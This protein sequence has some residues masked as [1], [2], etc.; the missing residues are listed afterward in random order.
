MTMHPLS[1]I[2]VLFSL[3]PM[4]WPLFLFWAVAAEQLSLL[5][6]LETF[7]LRAGIPIPG[8]FTCPGKRG[9]QGLKAVEKIPPERVECL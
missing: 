3:P 1:A 6:Y 2:H 5:R 7:R 9:G 8:V 4:S